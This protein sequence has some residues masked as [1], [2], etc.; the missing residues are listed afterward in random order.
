MSSFTRGN[1][2][3]NMTPETGLAF[4]EVWRMSATKGN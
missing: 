2:P 4:Q 3:Q 1:I